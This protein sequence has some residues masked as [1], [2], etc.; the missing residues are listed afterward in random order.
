MTFS[1]VFVVVVV[2]VVVDP[3]VIVVVVVAVVTQ[4]N[5]Q[6]EKERQKES[7]DWAKSDE[8]F[9][10]AMAVVSLVLFLEIFKVGCHGLRC[11]LSSPLLPPPLHL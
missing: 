11:C 2:V 3:A 9:F 6:R 10:P 7:S 4:V 1:L 5:L 8:R